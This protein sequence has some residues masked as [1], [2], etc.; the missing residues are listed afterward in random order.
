M[1]RKSRNQVLQE[2]YHFYR[3]QGF[4]SVEANKLKHRSL[5]T[6]G[7]DLGI[8][9]EGRTYLKNNESFR[10]RDIDFLIDSKR[11]VE[12]NSVYSRWGNVTQNSPHD[13][14]MLKRATYI[15]K[16]DKKSLDYGYYYLYLMFEKGYSNKEV[17]KMAET[18]KSFEIY[19]NP[20]K[21]IAKERQKKKPISKKVK[22]SRKMKLV[23]LYDK[24][25]KKNI[26]VVVNK[27]IEGRQSYLLDGTKY[28]KYFYELIDIKE[29][30]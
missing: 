7:F 29:V 24:R 10:E 4:S 20:E 14:D 17:K 22:R 6:K 21:V 19:I 8:N 11:K 16:R 1:S 30:D 25:N 27:F 9:R 5:D 18:D 12:N 3:K 2:R 23:I 28:T 15:A 13:D 26:S